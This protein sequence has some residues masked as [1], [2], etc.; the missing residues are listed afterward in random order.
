MQL[1]LASGS[2][3]RQSQL[4]S[5]GLNFEIDPA[6][7]DESRLEGESPLELAQRLARQKA[8]LVFVRYSQAL[9]I[10]GDQVCALGN[11][12]LNKPGTHERAIAQLTKLSGQTVVFHSAVTVMGMAETRSFCVNTEVAFRYLTE[13][14]IRSY[15]ELDKPLDCAGAIRSEGAGSLLFESVRS[16]DPTALIGL[17]LIELSK[18]LRHF[19]VNPL[20]SSDPNS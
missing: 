6:N 12:V 5:L 4:R 20:R 14:E 19:G 16:N 17:P 9:V 1:V 7:I 3:Y 13:K 18:A 8:N 10:A 15:V 11:E 2:R